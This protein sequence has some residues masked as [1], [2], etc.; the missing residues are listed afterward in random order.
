M[1]QL[2][3]LCAEYRPL[4]IEFPASLFP[5]LQFPFSTQHCLFGYHFSTMVFYSHWFIIAFSDRAL[6]SNQL[7]GTIP[8]QLGNLTQLDHLYH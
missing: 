7:E 2:Q 6:D 4:L 1:A 3:H 8:P 5:V